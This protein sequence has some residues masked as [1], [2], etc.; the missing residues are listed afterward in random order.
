MSNQHI[1]RHPSGQPTGGQF[2]ESQRASAGIALGLESDGGALIVA[3][4]I[5]Q[6]EAEEGLYPDVLQDRSGAVEQMRANPDDPALAKYARRMLDT[7]PELLDANPTWQPASGVPAGDEMYSKTYGGRALTTDGQYRSTTEINKMIRADIK[8]AV[9]GG[10]LPEDLDYRV[11]KHDSSLSSSINITAE[12]TGPLEYYDRR[13]ALRGYGEPQLQKSPYVK[14]IE[15]RLGKIAFQYNWDGSDTQSDYFDVNFYQDARVVSPLDA[16]RSRAYELRAK[17][18]KAHKA[19]DQ[20]KAHALLADLKRVRRHHD[21]M[22]EMAEDIARDLGA[23]V[24]R[25]SRP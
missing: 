14:E 4:A 3:D 22:Y 1:V 9:A 24:D 2:A 23:Q 20:E 13:D 11:H 10:Y 17:S 8:N 7:A 19:G 5:D 12:G 16:A 25:Y 21:D 6:L 18:A 15:K